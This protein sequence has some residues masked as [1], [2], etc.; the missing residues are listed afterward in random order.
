MT[1][2]G[3]S[4]AQ[5]DDRIVLLTSFVVELFHNLSNNLAN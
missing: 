4:G 1:A 2:Y 5:G 3:F